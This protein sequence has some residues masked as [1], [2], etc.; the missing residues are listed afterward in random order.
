[1]EDLEERMEAFASKAKAY[2]DM[3]QQPMLLKAQLHTPGIT[4]PSETMA[5]ITDVSENEITQIVSKYSSLTRRQKNCLM[6]RKYLDILPSTSSYFTSFW[7]WAWSWF[8][9]SD[10]HE[11]MKSYRTMAY[12][13]LSKAEFN[14]PKLKAEI[15][16][17]IQELK[18]MKVIYF[19]KYY[20]NN[21]D[22]IKKKRDKKETTEKEIAIINKKIVETRTKMRALKESIKSKYDQLKNYVD[23]DKKKQQSLKAVFKQIDELTNLKNQVEIVSTSTEMEE[24]LNQLDYSDTAVEIKEKLSISYDYEEMIDSLNYLI[25]KGELNQEKLKTVKELST[26]MAAKLKVLEKSI[27][28]LKKIITKDIEE[29]LKVLEKTISGDKGFKAYK[30]TIDQL[31]NDKKDYNDLKQ[32]MNTLKVDSEKKHMDL[33]TFN[34]QEYSDFVLPATVLFN[35]KSKFEQMRKIHTYDG[36]VDLNAPMDAK[37]KKYARNPDVK[38]NDYLDTLSNTQFIIQKG[39][40]DNIEN[41]LKNLVGQM[42]L[43]GKIEDHEKRLDEIFGKL[44]SKIFEIENQSRCFTISQISFFMFN[45]FK[46]NVVANQHRFL[47][48]FLTNLKFEHAREF[49]LYNLSLFS[50]KEFISNFENAFSAGHAKPNEVFELEEEY[51]NQF[52]VN[53]ISIIDLYKDL[54]EFQDTSKA[55]ENGGMFISV[56]RSVAVNLGQMLIQDISEYALEEFI[57]DLLKRLIN[58]IPFISAIPFLD[59]VAS[60]IV[61]TVGKF[62]T[63]QL[64][65]LF[66]KYGTMIYASMSKL[67]ASFK[68]KKYS[69]D[70]EKIIYDEFNPDPPSTRLDISFKNLDKIYTEANESETDLYQISLENSYFYIPIDTKEYEGKFRRDVDFFNQYVVG[71]LVMERLFHSGIPVSVVKDDQQYDLSKVKDYEKKVELFEAIYGA[72]SM[73]KEYRSYFIDMYRVK[74]YFDDCEET[75]QISENGLMYLI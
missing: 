41:C 34:V 28:A 74:G 24:L 1:M 65:K 61:W 9:S 39:M 52:V 64:M 59:E 45:M 12:N 55:L 56:W 46:T 15:E 71:E 25:E 21:P 37:T 3:P 44:F 13:I 40:D 53:Y 30:K 47:I 31:I 29:Q 72:V 57:K 27:T 33:E 38:F 22:E 10:P 17:K 62:I 42:Y 51:I 49:V 70:F 8:T 14:E 60:Y 75:S 18:T 2:P 4:I 19:E 69:L 26:D 36:M 23:N 11:E 66:S 73:S 6:I 7:S 67:M 68:E 63:K 35:L 5:L 43:I 48:T 16:E 20:K 50:T 54:T 58:L 32:E